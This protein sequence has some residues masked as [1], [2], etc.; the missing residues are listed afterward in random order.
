MRSASLW[1]LLLL[2][3]GCTQKTRL[4]ASI[5][6]LEDSP[7][8]FVLYSLDPGPLAHD[9]SIQTE[10]IFHGYDILGRAEISDA[11]ERRALVRALARGARENDGSMGL[12]FNPRHGLHVEQSGRSADFVICFECLQVH[13]YGFQLGDSF[14]TSASPEPTFNESLRKHHLPFPPK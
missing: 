3:C 11:D 6:K 14:L 5:T 8:K 9:E 4:A 10:T 12:C 2:V 1:L 13:A 7:S